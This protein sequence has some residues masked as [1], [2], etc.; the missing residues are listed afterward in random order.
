M[1]IR[2]FLTALPT[3][4][5]IA[6]SH[7]VKEE[8]VN[9]GIAPDRVIVRHLGVDE[10]R[11]CP[12]PTVKESWAT[13]YGIG[14][15]EFVLSMVAVLRP[16][17]NPDT[18]LRACGLVAKHGVALRLFVAGDGAMLPELKELSTS[19]NIERRVEWL[20]YCSD[21]KPVLQASDAFVLASVGEA[22]DL[23]FQKQWPRAFQSLEVVAA[24]FRT[25]AQGEK[26]CRK[27][28][29]E[30]PLLEN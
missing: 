21:P 22:F 20:G 1:R 4:R 10:E 12:D 8:L 25:T 17:K 29:D 5:L 9:R 18:I 27:A 24:R 28:C 30:S 13:N 19:L 14:P 23:W 15:N 7:F 26:R 2:T 6:I 16:F 11:F 3:T